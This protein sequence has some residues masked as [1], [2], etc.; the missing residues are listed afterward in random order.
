MSV[1]YT[2]TQVIA[3][4]TQLTRTRLHSFV[5]ADIVTPVLTD[6][7][8]EFRD[9]D[10]VRLELLCDL[11][12]AFDLEED[13]L[14]VIMSLIDQLHTTRSDLNR[15]LTA[16]SAESED[17]QRRISEALIVSRRTTT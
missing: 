6:A 5:Q 9:I 11:T 15:V 14:A 13:A 17:V 7:G 1:R 3:A 10:R 4:V 8:P 16:V 2:E 12:E